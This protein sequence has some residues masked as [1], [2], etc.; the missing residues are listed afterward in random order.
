MQKISASL[1]DL[2]HDQ[3]VNRATGI[4]KFVKPSTERQHLRVSVIKGASS[5]AAGYSAVTG[6]QAITRFHSDLFHS[7]MPGD[8]PYAVYCTKGSNWFLRV[9]GKHVLAVG[10]TASCFGYY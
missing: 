6:P 7:V 10:L 3:S 2:R 5:P 1:Q 8:V 4:K 9:I